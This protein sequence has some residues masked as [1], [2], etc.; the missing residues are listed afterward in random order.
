MHF[1]NITLSDFLFKLTFWKNY[2]QMKSNQDNIY[3]VLIY[4]GK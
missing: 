4:D 1:N 2:K 3:E